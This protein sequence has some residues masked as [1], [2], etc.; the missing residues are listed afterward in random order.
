MATSTLT[1]T[2][3]PFYRDTKVIAIILQVVFAIL[4]FLFAWLL[5][6]N[7][8]S[9]LSAINNSAGSPLTWNFFG[10]TAGFEISEGPMFPP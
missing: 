6:S 4:V 9:E 3:P 10:Q 2:R 1:S 8:M 5:Y 7:M